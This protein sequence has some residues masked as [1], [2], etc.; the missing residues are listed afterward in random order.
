MARHFTSLQQGNDC[1]ETKTLKMFGLAML[2][3]AVRIAV[4]FED[5]KV[6]GLQLVSFEILHLCLIMDAELVSEDAFNK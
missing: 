2:R 6:L 4:L 5:Y 3:E 1:A